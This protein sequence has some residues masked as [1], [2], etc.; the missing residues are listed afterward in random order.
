VARGPID[1]RLLRYASAARSF[2]ILGAIV[3]LAQTLS[4]VAAAWGATMVIVGLVAGSLDVGSLALFGVA[5]VVRSASVWLLDALSARGAARVK[6]EL[7]MRVV[8][9]IAAHGPAWL[10]TRNSASVTTVVGRG[11]DA[12]DG[13]FSKYLPQL[14]LTAIAMPVI[15]LVI[16][17]QDFS[18]A[19]I[20]AITLPLIPLFMVLVGWATQAVQRQ[21][22]TALTGLATGF[23]EVV[24]GLS[25]LTIF[26]RQHRQEK[27]IERVTEGYRSRTMAVLRV[28]FI[29]GFVLELAGS[30]SVAVVAVNIGVRLV[31][32]TLP[33]SVGLFVLLITPEIY[34][35]IRQVGAQFH[36]SADGVAA[37]EDVFEILEQPVSAVETV[38]PVAPSGVLGLSALSVGYDGRTVVDNFSGD[39]Q[40][41]KLTVLAAPSGAGKSSIVA[42]M[43]GFV[44]Y[45]GAISLGGQVL[46]PGQAREYIAWAGQKP[47]LAAGT[48]E[49]NIAL[50]A[51]DPVALVES[52][53]VAA[54]DL[55]APE[56]VLGVGGS[57]LSGGQAQRVSIARAVY[58]A[59]TERCSV[60]VL[61]EP[62][63]ALDL[64][65]EGEV[66]RNLQGLASSGIT[67]IVVSHRDAV[68][69]AADTVIEL[70]PRV[71]A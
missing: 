40:P 37:A 64:V 63:S 49:E 17:T 52:M 29:S 48:V 67:V 50:G 3:G 35:P 19:V 34:L 43:L 58:R 69:A 60:L 16:L 59:L 47:A 2:L 33:L 14:I 70:R 12:L 46:A 41:G 4:I 56:L 25:T 1:P 27:R 21:Q 13:Y 22:W 61:D 20:I 51:A 68:I 44:P 55:I 45:S 8:A 6:S 53:R 15:L 31:D 26:G 54:A 9:A 28:S 24:E 38:A 71:I 42:A 10:A 7:R 36:A 62:T 5:V 18:T 66:I 57:G 65:T 11:L 30:L 32:G 39:F 23:L